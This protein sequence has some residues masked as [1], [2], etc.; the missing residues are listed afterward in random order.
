MSWP[1]RDA[2]NACVRACTP[3]LPQSTHL[4]KKC[5][6]VYWCVYTSDRYVDANT[7]IIV[8]VL[9]T[10]THFFVLICADGDFLYA[11]LISLKM[12]PRTFG[13]RSPGNRPTK[14]P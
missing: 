14:S 2:T 4:P 12:H 7:N 3:T 6:Y 9:W 10:L 11:D 13:F 1:R 8:V 5:T